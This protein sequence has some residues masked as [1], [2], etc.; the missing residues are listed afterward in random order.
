MKEK[1]LKTMWHIYPDKKQTTTVNQLLQQK[2][3]LIAGSPLL[4]MMDEVSME[5]ERG[6]TMSAK[7]SSTSSYN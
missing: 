3:P 1:P 2:G 4:I 5:K 6:I 7:D